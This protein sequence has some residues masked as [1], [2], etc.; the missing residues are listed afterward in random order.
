MG[1]TRKSLSLQEAQA[2]NTEKVPRPRLFGRYSWLITAGAVLFQVFV[3]IRFWSLTWDDSAITLGFARTFAMTGKIEP[4]PGAGVVE[5]FSTL[6]WMFLMALVAKITTPHG[7]LVA[8]KLLTLCL[9]LVNLF[10]IRSFI[11]KFAGVLP[12]DLTAGLVGVFLMPYETINGMETPLLMCLLLAMALLARKNNETSEWLLIALGS[13]LVV[14]RYEALWW[15]I[16][17]IVIASQNL[18][19]VRRAAIWAAVFG[20]VSIWRYRYFGVWL[21]NT[22]IAKRGEPYSPEGFIPKL[23]L[24]LDGLKYPLVI[25]FAFLVLLFIVSGRRFRLHFLTGVSCLR[26]DFGASELQELRLCF[27]V[28]I[29][30][31]LLCLGVGNNWGPRAREFYPAWPF[32]IFLVISTVGWSRKESGQE[33]HWSLVL[34]SSQTWALVLSTVLLMAYM[35]QRLSSPFA[36][37]YMAGTTVNN[38]AAV[39]NP[40]NQLR[41]ASG[42]TALVYAAPDIGGVMLFGNNV[43]LVDLGLLCD[44]VLAKQRAAAIDSYVLKQRRPDVIEVHSSWTNQLGFDTDPLLP[45]EYQILII[46]GFRFFV[47]NDVLKQIAPERLEHREFAADG[48]SQSLGTFSSLHFIGYGEADFRLNHRFGSYF[49]L[50]PAAVS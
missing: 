47:R 15:T 49:V 13:L 37:V 5:G 50:L 24:H 28:T 17:F 21:P 23:L 36:P 35:V 11:R 7:L 43:G 38:V 45:S 29:A 26:R 39:L 4:T 3:A 8:A 42:K 20:V 6:S 46:Q 1:R 41:D 44:P 19:R 32:A 22:I 31:L 40:L 25:L 10:L 27:L 2:H 14:T 34:T 12:A 33:A 30:G 9:N 16:P 48:S 18:L